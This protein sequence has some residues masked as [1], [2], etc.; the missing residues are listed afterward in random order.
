MTSP[1]DQHVIGATLDENVGAIDLGELLAR[2]ERA[3]FHGR[4]IAGVEPLRAAVQLA[5]QQGAVAESLGAS[6]L[7]GVCLAAAGKFG[8]AVELLEPLAT[9]SRQ[10]LDER[11]FCSLSA[12]TLASIYRQLGRH[13]EAQ[14]VDERALNLAGDA[15]EARFDAILGLAADAVGL[16]STAEAEAAL[17]EATALATD[18]TDWWR[19]RVR[20][21]WT[22]AE[23]ALMH[24]DPA[25]AVAAAT[26]A[27]NRAEEAGAPRH[28]AKGLLFSGVAYIEL[29]DLQSA[30]SCL[31]RAATLAE[32]VGALPLVWPARA[33]LGALLAQTNAMESEAALEAARVAVRRI[34]EDLPSGTAQAW[35]ARPDVAALLEK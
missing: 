29:S 31:R 34:A 28:V 19:Q 5:D 9:S 16:G 14:Q 13:A 3:A 15:A 4:P 32:S 2:G 24:D 25:A 6:W 26:E 21:G 22:R 33:V 18:R 27:V 20:L 30:T 11:L 8:S 12:A 23:V 1:A 7:L 35:F 17:I 10:S